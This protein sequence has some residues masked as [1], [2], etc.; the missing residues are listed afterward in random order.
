MQGCRVLL[1]GC[2]DIG[3]QLG[4]RLA[5]EGAQVTG[6]R[7][8]SQP[9][10]APLESLCADVTKPASL[11]VLAGRCFDY[12]VVTLVPA[13]FSEDAYR[14]VFVAG[15]GNLLASLSAPQQIKR[16]LFVSST[17]VYHQC[18]CEEVDE[19][20][21]T[22]PDSFS[23]RSLLAAGQLLASSPVA[24]SV[25]RFGGIYGPGRHR[26]IQQVLDG[27]GCVRQPPAYS[28]C[29]HRD[30]CVGFLA[31][32]CRAAQA[33]QAL[34]ASY[35][36]VDNYSAPLWEVKQWLAMQLGVSFSDTGSAAGSQRSSKRCCNQRMRDSGYRLQYKDFRQGYAQVIAGMFQGD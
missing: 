17:S 10:I 29:I 18:A 25:V 3:I 31:H 21:V 32:L 1:V 5:R 30:D 4:L 9:L 15:L 13:A 6:L 7:R 22:E 14:S 2:G 24:A 35:L 23:G 11:A 16:L 19:R 26:L 8:S 27:E 34:E 28:N 33:G 36:A 20:S 12:V